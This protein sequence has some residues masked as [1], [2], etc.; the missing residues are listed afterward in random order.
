MNCPFWFSFYILGGICF[1]NFLLKVQSSD[2]LFIYFLL[3]YYL[4]FKF[5]IEYKKLKYLLCLNVKSNLLDFFYFFFLLN[6]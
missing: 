4:I 5:L 3:T 6:T 1:F 2:R